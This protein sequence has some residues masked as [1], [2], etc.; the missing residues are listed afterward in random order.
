MAVQEKDAGG[1]GERRGWDTLLGMKVRR[2]W[3]TSM[4]AGSIL[5]V[6][7][8]GFTDGFR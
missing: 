7:P 2:V 3:K 4:D 1:A 5:K 8:T 6:E